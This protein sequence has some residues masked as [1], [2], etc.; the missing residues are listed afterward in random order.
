MTTQRLR[1][2]SYLLCIRIPVHIGNQVLRGR[3]LCRL[4]RLGTVSK[5][6]DVYR[7]DCK[8]L[9]RSREV[10]LAR[11]CY[12]SVRLC[13]ESVCMFLKGSSVLRGKLGSHPMLWHQWFLYK[14][15]QDISFDLAKSIPLSNSFLVSKD[16]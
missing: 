1:S 15:R 16:I 12:S 13:R 6:F 7:Q 3:N 11:L 4:F 14:F 2:K 8:S 5:Q 10:K 9:E